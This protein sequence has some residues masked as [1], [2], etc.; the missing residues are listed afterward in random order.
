M[1]RKHLGAIEIA[2]DIGDLMIHKF[3]L[4]WCCLSIMFHVIRGVDA[5]QAQDLKSR[6]NLS[7]LSVSR[8]IEIALEQNRKRRISKLAVDTAEYQHKQALSSFWPRVNLE[9][10]Y[11]HQ[12]EDVNFIL[13]ENTYAY[14]ITLPGFGALAGQTTVPRQDVKVMDRES[15]L[16]SLNITYPIFTG[17]LRSSAVHAAESNIQAARQAMRR[18][19]L[20]LARDVQRMYYGVVLAQRLSDI[21]EETLIRLETTA[22][23]TERLYK[24]GSGSVTK[25]DYLRSQVVLESARSIVERLTSNV[26]LAKA[27]LGNTMGLGWETAFALSESTIPFVE[28]DADLNKLVAG[29]YQFNPDWRR[30]AAGLDAAQA[31]VK[32]ERSGYWPKVALKGTLWRWDNNLDGQGMATKE[33]EEGWSVGLGMQMPIFTGFMTTH[34]IKEAK[35]RLNKMESQQI[36]LKEGLALQ[37]KHGVIRLNRSRNIRNAS[38]KAVN[39]AREHRE[40]SVK[41]YMNELVS[42]EVVIESQIFEAM[43]RVKSE[44]AQFEN[45][46]ARFDIDFIVGQEVKKLLEAVN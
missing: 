26:P 5:A 35:A 17:G 45:A 1:T 24:E 4:V 21:G 39:H 33:N 37:V 13:P 25:L 46:A 2:L 44:M 36:L 18:T 7:S 43:A 31:L 38:L 29:A 42:T 6:D 15:V 34:K 40:L 8:C 41:A 12:D 19:N 28:V 32:K 30:L 10:A 3:T 9:A 11:K 20:E 22:E 27:A 16:S 14:H 23:L